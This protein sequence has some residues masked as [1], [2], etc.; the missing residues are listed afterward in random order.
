LPQEA[1]L[2]E[3]GRKYFGTGQNPKLVMVLRQEVRL[4]TQVNAPDLR[5]QSKVDGEQSQE[6]KS[7]P[8]VMKGLGICPQK[9]KEIKDIGEQHVGPA[10]NPKELTPVRCERV[11]RLH[12]LPAVGSLQQKAMPQQN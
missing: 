6:A 5:N 7:I 9:M 1:T 10:R 12:P 11:P 8:L 3:K 2:I 4:L